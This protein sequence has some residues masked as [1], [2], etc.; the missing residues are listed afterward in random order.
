MSQY[1]AHHITCPIKLNLVPF[2]YEHNPGN[3]ICV[4]LIS[5]HYK[6][7]HNSF[8]KPIFYILDCRYTLVPIFRWSEKTSEIESRISS[9]KIHFISMKIRN[10]TRLL[11]DK[12]LVNWD[13][14]SK[15]SFLISV[16][17]NPPRRYRVC[18]EFMKLDR[19][20]VSQSFPLWT[21]NQ[22]H[23]ITSFKTKLLLYKQ[24]LKE[25]Y[26]HILQQND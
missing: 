13:C 9:S 4:Q 26:N 20:P 14:F 25:T 23:Q 5:N 7:R 24:M 19:F 22:V 2:K 11:I 15:K 21:W 10:C 3:G 1:H 18:K 8:C 16:P 12:T 17:F 6:N